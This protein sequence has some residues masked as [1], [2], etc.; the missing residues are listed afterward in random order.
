MTVL[1][2]RE[3]P[4]SWYGLVRRLFNFRAVPRRLWRENI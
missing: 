1:F 2:I 3:V 4:N